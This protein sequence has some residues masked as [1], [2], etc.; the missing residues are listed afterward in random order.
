VT[1]AFLFLESADTTVL[2]RLL[3]S[4]RLSEI[5]R[6][7]IDPEKCGGRPIVRGLRI[8]VKDILD[9]LASGASREEIL[10]DYPSL[11]DGDITA[12]LEYASRQSDHPI[13]HVA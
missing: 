11:E 12:V 2:L 7:T 4:R 10:Q 5:H 8:R 6:I 3:R 13:L 1:R 9:L